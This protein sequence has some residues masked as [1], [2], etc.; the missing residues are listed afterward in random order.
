MPQDLGTVFYFDW[1]LRFLHFLQSIHNPI[2]DSIMLFFTNSA[3]IISILIF[4]SIIFPKTRRIGIQIYLALFIS[5]LIVNCGMKPFIM[6]CRPCWL[7]PGVKMLIELPH[8]HSFPSGHSSTFFAMATAVF[9]SNKRF[10]IP[11][12]A[13][14]SIVAFSRLYLFA[15]WPTDVIGGI[16]T[17]TLSGVLSF[18]IID[19]LINIFRKKVKDK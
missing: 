6:R 9:L 12:L 13:V 3:P 19:A 4:V 15:H 16:L 5:I 2:L 17:G 11:T 10:G 18:L 7:E 1:E 14:A 8:S